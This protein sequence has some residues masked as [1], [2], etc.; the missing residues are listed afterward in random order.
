MY[1][2][3]QLSLHKRSAAAVIIVSS[4]SISDG[5]V[6]MRKRYTTKQS[7]KEMCQEQ[8]QEKIR[9]AANATAIG[10]VSDIFLISISRKELQLD[11][12]HQ[13]QSSASSSL[14]QM[15]ES[16]CRRTQGA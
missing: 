3:N 16:H 1:V 10:F 7:E 8:V 15:H 4:S 5:P 9:F 2:E 14:H 13:H 12:C 6:Q 11:H